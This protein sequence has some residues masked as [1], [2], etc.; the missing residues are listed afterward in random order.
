MLETAL[1]SHRYAL[2]LDPENA[3]SLF[4]TSQ[5]LTS[6]AEEI[7]K[8][9]TVEDI[10]A[11]PL[12]EEAL[13]L[14]NQCLAVQELR[15]EESQQERAAAELLN[16]PAPSDG[17]HD[18]VES[19]SAHSSEMVLQEDQ[20]ASV[21]E[22]V[23][24]DTLI[25]TVLAQLGTLT[26][27]CSV[28]ASAPV[29]TP[30]ASLPW[31]EEYSSKLLQSKLPTYLETSAERHQEIALAKANFIST[32]LEAGFRMGKIDDL[33]Y[34]RE[35]DAVFAAAE[36]DIEN[37]GSAL[38]ANA[39]SLISF[40]AALSEVPTSATSSNGTVRWNALSSAITSLTKASKGADI[41]AEELPK[42]HAL[43]ADCSLLQ[44]QLGKPPTL[45]QLAITNASQLLK[46]AEVFYRNAA[47]LS[48][49]PEERD[50][51]T[52]RAS[53]LWGIQKNTVEQVL[54]LASGGRDHQWK[55]AQLEE[56]IDEGLL[57]SDFLSI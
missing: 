5:V 17:M 14:Q 41:P 1:N 2:S 57:S 29:V 4:N 40:N 47:K 19:A 35:R 50:V 23:T 8:D 6:I 46:N 24:T 21:V 33:I 15:F 9:D 32:L 53:V 30:A 31:V 38:I 37:S 34:K 13:E 54:T 18:A 25:D 49:D 12:L 20:W 16:E 22:P 27:L 28:L 55:Q 52:M 3:G 26:T 56:M 48:Q 45:F 7:M 36:L 51:A 44:Y 43:R 39:F 11:L 10:T 42:T